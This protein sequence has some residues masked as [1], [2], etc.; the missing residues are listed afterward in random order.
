MKQNCD[1]CQHHSITWPR[2]DFCG[3]YNR[4]I[5]DTRIGCIMHKPKGGQQ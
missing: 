4:Y 5:H 2:H 3:Y 1:N